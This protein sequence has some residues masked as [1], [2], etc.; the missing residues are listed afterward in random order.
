MQNSSELLIPNS[1]SPSLLGLN[2]PLHFLIALLKYW[3]YFNYVYVIIYTWVQMPVDARIEH[4]IPYS[5]SNK[6]GL[7]AM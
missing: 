1:I 6:Q 3:F 4:R 7:A 2:T 5:W